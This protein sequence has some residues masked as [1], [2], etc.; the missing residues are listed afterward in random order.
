MGRLGTSILTA[1][2]VLAC[3]A[4]AVAVDMDFEQISWLNGSGAGY[5]SRYSDWGQVEIS[6]SAGDHGQFHVMTVQGVA[7]SGGFINIVSDA[8]GTTDW[9]VQNLPIFYTNPTDLDGRLPQGVWFDLGVT[10]GTAVTSLNYY[11]TIDASPLAAMPSGSLT[12]ASVLEFKQL[13]A[14]T[15]LWVGPHF[16]GG[17]GLASPQPAMNFQGAEAGEV[18]GSVSSITVPETSVAAVNEDGNG[19]APGSAARSVKYLGD[20]NANVNVPATAQ[21]VYTGL[22]G[23][24]GTVPQ[25]TYISDILPGKQAYT[26]ANGMPIVSANTQSFHGAMETLGQGGDVELVVSWGQDA[27]GNSLGAHATFVSEVQELVDASGNTTGYVVETIDD[28]TQGDGTAENSTHTLK[29]DANGKLLQCDGR[30]AATGAGLIHFMVEKARV[31]R[32]DMEF[33]IGPLSIFPL[34]PGSQLPNPVPI[35]IPSKPAKISALDIYYSGALD[36]GNPGNPVGSQLVVNPSGAGGPVAVFEMDLK[37]VTF[38]PVDPL[39]STY[40]QVSLGLEHLLPDELSHGLLMPLI[41]RTGEVFLQSLVTT[42]TFF[43]I[44]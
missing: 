43:D 39:A 26:Q 23:A 30:G 38:T 4:P 36:S 21:Q 5:A 34:P 42:S 20:T 9:E 17:G 18:I 40:L 2:A 29:F 12:G 31:S 6:L 35:G 37:D 32:E 33:R 10:P 3:A 1:L 7:G 13:L 8:N 44:T 16:V 19:C 22:Y 11:Y 15:T 27:D 25:G 41:D 28:P 24:M 14:G